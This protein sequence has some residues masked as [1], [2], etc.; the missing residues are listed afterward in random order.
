MQG[1]HKM[2]IVMQG[3]KYLREV[4][5]QVVEGTLGHA[6]WTRGEI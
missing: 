6:R 1:G 3:E 2:R 5:L 4:T